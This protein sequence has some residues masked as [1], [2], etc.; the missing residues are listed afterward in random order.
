[1]K[2][3]DKDFWIEEVEDV[4]EFRSRPPTWGV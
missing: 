4:E 2:Y 1:M 3:A